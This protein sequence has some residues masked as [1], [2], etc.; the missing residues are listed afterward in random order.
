MVINVEQ[1]STLT[2]KCLETNSA[3]VNGHVVYE[4]GAFI[5]EG[6]GCLFITDDVRGSISGATVLEG[7][8]VL[9]SGVSMDVGANAV[10]GGT[11][12]NVAML[13]TGEIYRAV[14]G[15]LATAHNIIKSADGVNAAVLTNVTLHAGTSS[16]YATLQNVDFAGE[17]TL[18]GYITFEET[19]RQ[20]DMRV[21][22]GGTLTVDNVCFDLHGLASGDKVL[23]EN[24]AVSAAAGTLI[25]WETA[26]FVYS[27]ITV[28]S[29][30]VN[31]SVA[32]VVTLKDAHDGNLYWTGAADDK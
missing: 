32:G 21:A 17:S 31:T 15:G 28:N 25:G 6:S 22:A 27:G 20:R 23:I 10:S 24:A 12:E 7:E 29:A 5:K 9:A 18:R 3:V 30:A 13:V 4:S 26:H 8:L 2:L 16:E 14:S 1:D 11:L 19:Q